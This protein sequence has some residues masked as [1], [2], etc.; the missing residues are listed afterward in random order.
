MRESPT[1]K[2]IKDNELGGE[3][4]PTCPNTMTLNLIPKALYSIRSS[5]PFTVL[6]FAYLI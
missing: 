1:Y 4:K 5:T 6:Y 3:K 2:Q